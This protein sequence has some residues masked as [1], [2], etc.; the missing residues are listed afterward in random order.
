LDTATIA[1]ALLHDTIEDTVAT[2]EEIKSNF[3]D[4][5]AFLVD[6]VTKL[7]KIEIQPEQSPQAENFR[8]FM[9]AMSNDIR[10]LLVKLADRLHNMRT[11]EHV[12]PEK[13]VRVAQETMDIYAPLAGRMGMQEM[14]EELE[15]LSFRILHPEAHETIVARLK[16]LHA[17]SGNM[18]AEIEK[19]LNDKLTEHGISAVVKGREKKP[20]SIWNK[21]E[22]RA[23][24]LGQLSDIFGFRVI[25]DGIDDCYRALG[26][27]HQTWR[28]VPGRFK[29]YVSTPKQN[30][31]ASLHTTLIGPHHKRVE[32]QIRTSEM[33]DVAERGVAAHA[34]YKEKA[35]GSGQTV[36]GPVPLSEDSN[37]YR[38]LRSLVDMIAEG[39]DS[40]DFL[41]HTKLELFH[42]QV[43]CF[44]PQGHLIA[45]P[46]GATP[47][48]FAYAVHTDVGN[49][50]VGCNINGAQAPLIGELENGVEVEI[51]CSN[52]QVPPSAWEGIA[53]TGKAR[54]AIRRATRAAVNTQY[55]SLGAEILQRAAEHSGG[56]V[57]PDDHEKCAENLGYARAD[58]FLAAIGRGEQS[59]KEAVAVILPNAASAKSG[60][61]SNTAAKERRW[62]TLGKAMWPLPRK[63]ANQFQDKSRSR[64]IPI[65]GLKSDLPIQFSPQTGAVPGERIVGILTPG[66]GITI[67]PIHAAALE[68]LEKYPERWLDL[69]WDIDENH[70]DR[71]PAR[72]AVTVLND[73]GTLGQI[74][75]E[76]GES[77]GN[78]SNLT[79]NSREGDFF[80][81][82]IDVEVRDLKHL[83]EIISKLR[84]KTVVSKVLRL[85]EA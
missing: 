21:M 55:K 49:S 46:R 9:L 27:V 33:H 20:Y 31:Y 12:A 74:A 67:Y 23:M 78:I 65:R 54:S 28:M 41:E 81:M 68:N 25:V 15:G 75:V 16:V 14:R 26:V 76:I 32:L 19:E 40:K 57:K 52:A 42:D 79:M 83:N 29:D 45:L 73:V 58:D 30:D 22:R 56:S 53:V 61:K 71:F 72:L 34:L 35:N 59:V 4:E 3:G 36:S 39:D 70:D 69:T 64:A 48:D 84:R 77:D 50:C 80:E 44:T 13:A 11:L 17:E 1:T 37:A 38:W 2:S 8:K 63:R 10:V 82:N 6:G 43:F 47:I 85:N 18:I 7:S 62:Y 5:I 51:I 66:E 24:S 60:Q